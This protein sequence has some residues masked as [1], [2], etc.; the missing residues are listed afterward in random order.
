MA[1]GKHKDESL[2]LKARARHYAEE[3]AR[4]SA[5]DMMDATKRGLSAVLAALAA[6]TPHGAFFKSR[7]ELAE[8]AGAIDRAGFIC[9]PIET[10]RAAMQAITDRAF[11]VA[12]L[13][14]SEE[15]LTARGT[16]MRNG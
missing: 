9:L 12:Y 7:A 5:A 4:A 8:L 13:A 15:A 10:V 6:E 1:S 11:K 16:R 2:P 3:Q 14:G